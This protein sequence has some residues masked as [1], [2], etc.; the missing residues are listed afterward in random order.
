MLLILFLMMLDEKNLNWNYMKKICQTFLLEFDFV[1]IEFEIIYYL[2]FLRHLN[3]N[4]VLILSF[5]YNIIKLFS[6]SYILK[7]FFYIF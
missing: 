5:F 3:Y 2:E 1:F 7:I 4:F 6:C